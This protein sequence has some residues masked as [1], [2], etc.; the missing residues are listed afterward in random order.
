MKKKAIIAGIVILIGSYFLFS[1]PK[2]PFL[3]RNGFNNLSLEE[4]VESLESNRNET[5]LEAG[6]LGDRLEMT[7]SIGSYTMKIPK[8]KFYLSVAP[9]INQTHPCANHSLTGCQGE[10][11]NKK[12]K[13]KI[14][15]KNS[16]VIIDKEVTTYKNGFFGLWLPK[17]IEGTITV[18][19]EGKSASTTIT[20]YNNS[21]TCLT[22][23]KLQ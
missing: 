17:N 22:T 1:K 2:D 4:I 15:D 7:D 11:I 5:G 16:K 3:E 8:D 10:F 14:S 18:N 9:Y 23:L 13:V 19:Y 6:I 20:T 12:V 21:E